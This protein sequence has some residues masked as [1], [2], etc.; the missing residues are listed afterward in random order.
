MLAVPPKQGEAAKSCY[1]GRLGVAEPSYGIPDLPVG[2]WT[3]FPQVHPSNPPCRDPGLGAG[4]VPKGEARGA[5]CAPETLCLAKPSP[6]G[7]SSDSFVHGRLARLFQPVLLGGE[8]SFSQGRA[9][10]LATRKA[11]RNCKTDV[12]SGELEQQLASVRSACA[13]PFLLPFVLTEK[14]KIY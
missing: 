4:L 10:A 1:P 14:K 11:L 12:V 8:Q 7:L 2:R 5:A 6:P 3:V 13:G 9:S